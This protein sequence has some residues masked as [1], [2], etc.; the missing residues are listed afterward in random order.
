MFSLAVITSTNQAGA[1]PYG[2]YARTIFEKTTTRMKR[3]VVRSNLPEEQKKTIQP[4][5][6]LSCDEMLAAVS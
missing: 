1:A 2:L 3:R 6:L 4:E 5:D